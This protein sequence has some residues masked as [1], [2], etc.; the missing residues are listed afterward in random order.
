MSDEGFLGRYT[1]ADH[2][3]RRTAKAAHYDLLREH[4]FSAE[5]ARVDSAKAAEDQMR[6][7]DRVHSGKVSTSGTVSRPRVRVRF[8]W[9]P[10]DAGITLDRE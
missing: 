1:A 3:S 7:I 10:D 8:P 4:G 5:R 9:E 6:A 2:R